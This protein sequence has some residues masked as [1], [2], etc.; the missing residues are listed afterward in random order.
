VLFWLAIVPLLL[1]GVGG[2]WLSRKG[3]AVL[4]LR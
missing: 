1:L 4:K 3:S 2:F